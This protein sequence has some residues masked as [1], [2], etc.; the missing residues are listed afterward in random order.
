MQAI[1]IRKRSDKKPNK[2][3]DNKIKPFLFFLVF[4]VLLCFS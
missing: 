4:L 3:K 1:K 2:T